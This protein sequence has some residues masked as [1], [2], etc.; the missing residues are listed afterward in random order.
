[1]IAD[2]NFANLFYKLMIFW[3]QVLRA[4]NHILNA[5]AAFIDILLSG[6]AVLSAAL[7]EQKTKSLHVLCNIAIR[8]KKF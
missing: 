4:Q 6:N 5:L 1:M 7:G 3:T 8:L 2:N